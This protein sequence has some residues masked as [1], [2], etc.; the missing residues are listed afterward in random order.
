MVTDIPAGDGKISNLFLQCRDTGISLLSLGRP[1]KNDIQK[2]QIFYDRHL[3]DSNRFKDPRNAI[4]INQ[5][6][7]VIKGNINILSNIVSIWGPKY[8]ALDTKACSCW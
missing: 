7:F 8:T 2:R 5:Q 1:N 6:V 4:F 3:I